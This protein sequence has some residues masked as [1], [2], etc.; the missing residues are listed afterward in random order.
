MPWPEVVVVEAFEAAVTGGEVAEIEAVLEVAV[1]EL[2]GNSNLN[3]L[4]QVL[5]NIKGPS[6]QISLQVIGR[7]ARC[8]S[9]GVARRIFVL[10][11]QPAHGEMYSHQNKIKIEGLTS[12]ERIMLQSTQ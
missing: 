2:A 1:P 10:N 5:G 6:T 8:T 3:K 9:G 4:I 7:G 11:P 12:L